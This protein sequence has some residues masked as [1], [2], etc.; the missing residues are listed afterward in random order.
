[1]QEKILKILKKNFS[2]YNEYK[3]KKIANEIIEE[4]SKKNIE[5]VLNVTPSC[6]NCLHNKTLMVTFINENPM[7]C[8]KGHSKIVTD[9]RFCP[10]YLENKYGADNYGNSTFETTIS[11]GFKKTS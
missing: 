1:M 10:D 9:A 7:L 5:D 2:Q 11:R 3:L 8:L 6:A 4:L